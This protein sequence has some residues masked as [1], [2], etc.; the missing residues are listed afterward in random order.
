MRHSASARSPRLT[1]ASLEAAFLKSRFF[2]AYAVPIIRA[3]PPISAV[4][5]VMRARSAARMSAIR[6]DSRSEERIRFSHKRQAVP[7]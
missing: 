4:S 1:A 7:D 3:R 2:G 5:S 6:V